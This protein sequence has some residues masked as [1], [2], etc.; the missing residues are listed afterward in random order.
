MRYYVAGIKFS[1][2]NIPQLPYGETDERC[3][4]AVTHE[5]PFF[6]V[7][8][9]SKDDPARRDCEETRGKIEL[10]KTGP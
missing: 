1:A 8:K 10:S 4:Q 5:S 3:C 9:Y 2:N 6:P 7:C